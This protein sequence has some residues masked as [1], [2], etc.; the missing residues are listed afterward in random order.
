MKPNS[1]DLPWKIS[2]YHEKT[3][4]EKDTCTPMFIT[5]LITI[6]SMWEQ[7]RCPSTDEWIKKMCYIHTYKMDSWWEVAVQH[8]D[9][10]LALGDDLE[11]WDTGR[12]G[13]L[14]RE[15]MYI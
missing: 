10:S 5:A 8:G 3:R 4:T 6:A 13:R 14:G 9:P 12:G 1:K 15:G 2:I 11:G 7:P